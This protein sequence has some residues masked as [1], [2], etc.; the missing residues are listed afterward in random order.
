[1][2]ICVGIFMCVSNHVCLNV[3]ILK[4]IALD[5]YSYTNIKG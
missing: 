3:Y 1:M 2:L 4:K 5:I